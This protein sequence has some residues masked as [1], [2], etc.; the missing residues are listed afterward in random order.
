MVIRSLLCGSPPGGLIYVRFYVRKYTTPV[1]ASITKEIGVRMIPIDPR[2]STG[3]AGGCSS[4][5]SEQA[6]QLLH[7]RRAKRCAGADIRCQRDYP[8]PR[9]TPEQ[10]AHMMAALRRALERRLAELGGEA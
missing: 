7:K 5:R 2:W 4:L 10:E 9:V 3:G 1:T 6:G 8:P